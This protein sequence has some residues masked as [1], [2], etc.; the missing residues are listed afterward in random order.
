MNAITV[1]NPWSRRARILLAGGVL[2]ALAG[3]AALV[4]AHPGPWGGPPH[5]AWAADAGPGPGPGPWG[6]MMAGRRGQRMLEAAGVSA[7]QQAQIR[8]LFEAA[9][10]E[11]DAAREG[12][13]ALHEQMR[14]LFTQPTIDAAAA[15]ALR[16]QQ[17]ARIDAA[18]QRQLQLMLDVSRVLTPEQRVR[19]AEQAAQRKARMRRDGGPRPEK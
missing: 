14:Q 1:S 16:Q 5:Q 19:L 10:A 2:L 13:A 8:R 11:R 7:E 15:E 12:G 17:L 6:A 3:T 9:R 18:S 4:Q